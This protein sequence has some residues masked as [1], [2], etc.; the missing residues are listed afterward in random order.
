MSCCPAAWVGAGGAAPVPGDGKAPLSTPCS[1][2]QHMQPGTKSDLHNSSDPWQK[3][4][5]AIPL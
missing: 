2:D 4:Q 3:T 5:A 1:T